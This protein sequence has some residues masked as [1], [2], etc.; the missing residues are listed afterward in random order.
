VAAGAEAG[1]IGAAVLLGR[2]TETPP[3]QHLRWTVGGLA[4]GVAATVPL[5]LALRWCLHTGW[6]PVA[7][8]VALVHQR[9]APL[10]AGAGV[11]HLALLSILAGLGEEALFRGVIQE[12]LDGR[13]PTW[14]AVAATGALFG[15]AHWVSATYAVLAGVVG[16]YLG[17][18]Y[19]ATDNLLAPVVTHALYDLVALCILLRVKPV[20][21][22]FVV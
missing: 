16:L 8:L 19:V 3:F 20:A 5:L 1:L 14:V 15:A 2:W 22:H 9:L 7:R 6:G 18:L 17:G 10:F 13:F 4:W 12:A 21:R 11:S